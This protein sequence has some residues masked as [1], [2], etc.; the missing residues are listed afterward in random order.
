MCPSTTLPSTARRL[1][2]EGNGA[3]DDMV[4]A[5]SAAGSTVVR[6]KLVLLKKL[7]K[8]GGVARVLIG[9]AEAAHSPAVD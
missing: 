5:V 1:V 4:R 3:Y 2:Q 9:P 7:T 6:S 8:T